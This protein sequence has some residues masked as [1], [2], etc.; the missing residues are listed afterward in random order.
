MLQLGLS[1]ARVASELGPLSR[2]AAA[3]RVTNAKDWHYVCSFLLT[4]NTCISWKDRMVSSATSAS[5]LARQSVYAS[6]CLVVCPWE[7]HIKCACFHKDLRQYFRQV[8]D[9]PRLSAW[10]FLREREISCVCLSHSMCMWGG[11]T[12]NILR[13][14][15]EIL[16]RLLLVMRLIKIGVPTIAETCYCT[17]SL[18]L[19]AVHLIR[20]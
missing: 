2:K 13:A 20:D 8:P 14:A 18:E 12:S 4:S 17:C 15:K 6:V 7:T 11:W 1:S 16:G 19:S 5:P 9:P 3:D 10:D